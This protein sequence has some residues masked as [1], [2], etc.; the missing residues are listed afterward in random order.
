MKQKKSQK[1]RGTGV[2][3]WARVQLGERWG[4]DLKFLKWLMQKVGPKTGLLF[5]IQRPQEMKIRILKSK[6]SKRLGGEETLCRVDNE[7]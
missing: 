7:G 2:S 4:K 1:G 3:P 5:L 6:N